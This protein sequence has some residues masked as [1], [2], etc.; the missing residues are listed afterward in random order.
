MEQWRRQQSDWLLPESVIGNQFLYSLTVVHNEDWSRKV[1]GMLSMSNRCG[2]LTL[3]TG[4][5]PTQ[6][7]THSLQ[8]DREKIGQE[9]SL[10]KIKTERSFA[11]Y[12]CGQNYLGKKNK[13]CQLQKIWAER[14]KDKH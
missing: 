2:R 11:N 10:V 12:C 14:N 5:T 8:C 7:L 4:H 3:A 1:R 9:S 13:Y 6:P